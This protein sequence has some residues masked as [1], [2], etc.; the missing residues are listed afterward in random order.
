VIGL[1]LAVLKSRYAFDSLLAL[2]ISHTQN[3]HDTKKMWWGLDNLRPSRPWQCPLRL[4]LLSL[5]G[6]QCSLRM[7][8]FFPVRSMQRLRFYADISSSQ[9]HATPM[10]LC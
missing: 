2:N 7:L 3:K 1:I 8:I 4:R 5:R 6:Q 10:F 9:K